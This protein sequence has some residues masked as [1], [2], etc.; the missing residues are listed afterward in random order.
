MTLKLARRILS[1][2]VFLL[3]AFII[4]AGIISIYIVGQD[5]SVGHE[6]IFSDNFLF[7]VFLAISAIPALG[8]YILWPK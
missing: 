2:L 3:A 6:P 1:V 7:T 5:N 8:S 4:M